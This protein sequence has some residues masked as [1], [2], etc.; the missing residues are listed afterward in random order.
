MFTHAEIR[1]RW[2]IQT[3]LLEVLAVGLNLDH[4]IDVFGLRCCPLEGPHKVF[5]I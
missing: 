5:S 3:F 1:P 2:W 4:G